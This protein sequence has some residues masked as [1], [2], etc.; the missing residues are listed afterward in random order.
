MHFISQRT[1]PWLAFFLSA[2]ECG[3]TICLASNFIITTPAANIYSTSP[4]ILLHVS[5]DE[6]EWPNITL[7]LQNLQGVLYQSKVFTVSQVR[8]DLALKLIPGAR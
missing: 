2:F 4:Q 7:E 6:S 8:G 3:R 1:L 5:G